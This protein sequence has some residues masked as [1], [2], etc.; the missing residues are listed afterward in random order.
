[1]PLCWQYLGENIELDVVGGFVGV[2]Q[3]QETLAVRPAIGRAVCER[4]SES[5][6]AKLGDPDV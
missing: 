6:S 1:V 4:P 3:D 2:S 5:D